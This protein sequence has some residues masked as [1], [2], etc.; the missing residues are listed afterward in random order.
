HEQQ[1]REG[2]DTEHAG[3]RAVAELDERVDRHLLVELRC[4][5]ARLALWPG[6]AAE[7]RSR[8]S[9]GATGDD[10]ADLRHEVGPQRPTGPRRDGRHGGGGGAA[11]VLRLVAGRAQPSVTSTAVCSTTRRASRTSGTTGGPRASTRGP[12]QQGHRGAASGTPPC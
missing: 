5:L 8:E 2:E 1:D 6:R 7:A 10:D 3:E 11:H 4:E 9:H 12:T